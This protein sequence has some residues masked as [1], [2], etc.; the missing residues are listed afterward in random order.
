[1]TLGVR[2][3]QLDLLAFAR[4]AFKRLDSSQ[5]A[6]LRML[7]LLQIL[8]GKLDILDTASWDHLP[9]ATTITA[10][11][12]RVCGPGVIGRIAPCECKRKTIFVM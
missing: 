6:H 8:S 3:Q 1:M 10:D 9:D 2:E 5:R 12:W 4:R 11:Y 7:N